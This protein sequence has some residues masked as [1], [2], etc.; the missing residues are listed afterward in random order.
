MR[1]SD[2]RRRMIG[3]LVVVGLLALAVGWLATRNARSD[4]TLPTWH[5]N[6]LGLPLAAT[7]GTLTDRGGCLYVNDDLAIWP[8][9]YRLND[10]AVEDA[11]GKSVATVGQA[12]SVDGGEYPATDYDWLRATILDSDVSASCRGGSFWWVTRV[13]PG[14]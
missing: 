3:L 13:E 11:N 12:V 9:G 5:A 7:R 8:S 4:T 10:S 6:S 14:P 1:P 2:P